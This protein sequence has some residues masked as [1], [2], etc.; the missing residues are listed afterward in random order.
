VT[1][2][3]TK[4]ALELLAVL[5]L[6]ACAS[7]G[8]SGGTSSDGQAKIELAVSETCAAGSSAQCV[9]INGENVLTPP[10]FEDADVESAAAVESNG[11]S[12]VQVTFT[13]NGGAVLNT[14][15]AQAAKAGSKAR[16]VMKAD[17]DIIGAPVVMQAIE[18]REVSIVVSPDGN[19]QALA[20]S[21]LGH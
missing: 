19:A 7:G 15:T 5:A 6:S 13:D 17:G 11:Q 3:S 2:R 18:S 10:A 12:L 21:I 4:I 9:A 20:D 8:S 16:L 14:L 1:I